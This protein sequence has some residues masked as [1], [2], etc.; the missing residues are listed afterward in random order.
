MFTR[1]ILLATAVVANKFPDAH[2]DE[3]IAK[4]ASDKLD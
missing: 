3:Y 1:T 2:G 4:S